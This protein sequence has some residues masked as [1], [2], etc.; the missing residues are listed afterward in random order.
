MTSHECW[1]QCALGWMPGGTL[2]LAWRGTANFRNV[3]T[4]IK[5]FSRKVGV[6]PC[7]NGGAVAAAVC[8]FTKCLLYLCIVLLLIL[9]GL[10]SVKST[11][12]PDLLRACTACHCNLP[13]AS[14]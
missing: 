8:G 9:A 1:V 10:T 11:T 12:A 2:V 6:S 7:W 5:F 13:V 4:D 14:N 3:L